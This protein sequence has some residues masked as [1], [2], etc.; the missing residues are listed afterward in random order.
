M[1]ACAAKHANTPKTNATD[2]CSSPNV[3]CL[4]DFDCVGEV[5]LICGLDVGSKDSVSSSWVSSMSWASSTSVLSRMVRSKRG[6]C[7]QL[8]RKEQL[9]FEFT[10][11][12]RDNLDSL[13]ATW[14]GSVKIIHRTSFC[15]VG[16]PLSLTQTL[17]Y[18]GRWGNL[19]CCGLCM[20]TSNCEGP[21]P[22]DVR[23]ELHVIGGCRGIPKA[24][25]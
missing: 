21:S 19:T 14:N 23:S 9:Q 13:Y 2:I 10:T 11:P 6:C 22:G 5:D 7:R 1:T 12:W 24:S 17:S 25:Y 4:Q 8:K 16:I 3:Y 15:P 18:I 20:R